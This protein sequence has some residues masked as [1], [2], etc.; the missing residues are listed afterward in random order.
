MESLTIGDSRYAPLADSAEPATK[1]L[2]APHPTLSQVKFALARRLCGIG[3]TLCP[4]FGPGRVALVRSRRGRLAFVLVSKLYRQMYAN[5]GIATDSAR[6]S[7]SVQVGTLAG[8]PMPSPFR[9]PPYAGIGYAKRVREIADRKQIHR[10]ACVYL[11]HQS[12]S[13]LA[14]RSFIAMR[15]LLQYDRRSVSRTFSPSLPMTRKI[16]FFASLLLYS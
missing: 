12:Q 6:V 13:P 10:S 3:S 8:P 7:R 1:G 15:P 9:R 2:L 4:R 14:I 16:F 11:K 5:T